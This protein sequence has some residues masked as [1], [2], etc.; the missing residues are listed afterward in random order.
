MKS[1]KEML[2]L[3]KHKALK[4]KT[5][6]HTMHKTSHSRDYC[7]HCGEETSRS[8]RHESGHREYDHVDAPGNSTGVSIK[9]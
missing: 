3:S 7:R 4:K 6:E 9:G 8:I 2:G 5:G 1:V